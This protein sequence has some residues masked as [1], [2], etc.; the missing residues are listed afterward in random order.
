MPTGFQ[1]ACISVVLLSFMAKAIINRLPS[2]QVNL[3]WR[4]AKESLEEMEDRA[5]KDPKE[6][7]VFQF[8]EKM[9]WMESQDLQDPQEQRVSVDTPGFK[10]F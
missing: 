2:P 8:L 7:L 9:E 1:N 3:E 4:E 10:V 5:Q 6:G